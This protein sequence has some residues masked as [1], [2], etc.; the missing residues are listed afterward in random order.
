MSLQ[1]LKP[2]VIRMKHL[3]CGRA[4]KFLVA[5]I[6]NLRKPKTNFQIY[7]ESILLKYKALV[8]FLKMNNSE[9]YSELC[10][11]YCETMNNIYSSKLHQYF[12]DTFKLV[13]FK[14]SK[15]DLL[16][17]KENSD[18]AQAGINAKVFEQ[19]MAQVQKQSSEEVKDSE[20]LK[21]LQ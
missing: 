15:A 16:F 14:I 2:E 12:K 9:V 5:K 11:K 4:F 10:E 1:K 17:C 21:Q 20:I 19:C 13:Q 7:Q 3:V 8:Q 18:P 6:N